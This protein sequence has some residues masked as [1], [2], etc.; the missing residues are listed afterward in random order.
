[1]AIGIR[2]AVHAPF[3]GRK[4]RTALSEAADVIAVDALKPGL[5]VELTLRSVAPEPHDLAT[6]FGT[7]GAVD[8]RPANCRYAG[9]G[10][11]AGKPG[12]YASG[13]LFLAIRVA[14]ALVV[15][16]DE[17]KGRLRAAA[18]RLRYSSATATGSG[19]AVCVSAAGVGE[20]FADPLRARVVGWPLDAGEVSCRM[21]PACAAFPARLAEGAGVGGTGPRPAAPDI[22]EG[23]DGRRRPDQSHDASE[24]REP[25]RSLHGRILRAR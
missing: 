17:E 2:C 14:S 8:V 16:A 19:G 7:L 11:I 21:P 5:E 4:R 22:A 6:A 18:Y 9:V 1:M 24:C 10:R 12:G 25:I 3:L 13:A 15:D 23:R 20:P